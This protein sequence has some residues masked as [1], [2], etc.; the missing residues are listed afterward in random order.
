MRFQKD[1]KWLLLSGKQFLL[2]CFWPQTQ[3][4]YLSCFNS[5]RVP[6][7]NPEKAH[8]DHKLTTGMRRSTH[9]KTEPHSAV[10]LLKCKP[11]CTDHIKDCKGP[12][13][14]ALSETPN[15]FD[16]HFMQS[17]WDTPPLSTPRP[18]PFRVLPASA[19]SSP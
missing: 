16:S 3:N 5:R 11:K 19:V 4:W 14:G 13:K 15:S 17:L 18:P 10:H 12:N 1:F 6:R 7:C 9:Q 8:Q 2:V